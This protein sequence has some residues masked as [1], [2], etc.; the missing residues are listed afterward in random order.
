MRPTDTPSNN[1]PRH[2]FSPD[3]ERERLR[4]VY[5][6]NRQPCRTEHR[7]VGKNEERRRGSILR[8]L[9]RVVL[10]KTTKTS[11]KEKADALRDSAPP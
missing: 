8:G 4:W 3:F 7:C 10:E 2:P 9:I 11:C 1:A 5:P 6:R